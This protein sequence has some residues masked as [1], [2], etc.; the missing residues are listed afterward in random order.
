MRSEHTAT[1]TY[2]HN[3]NIIGKKFASWLGMGATYINTRKVPE[4]FRILCESTPHYAHDHIVYGRRSDGQYIGIG[5][6]YPMGADSLCEINEY[7]HAVGLDMTLTGESTW[8]SPCLRIL[9]QRDDENAERF[10]IAVNCS[11]WHGEWLLCG[12]TEKIIAGV[13]RRLGSHEK[14]HAQNSNMRGW[15]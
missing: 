5:Q 8:G 11:R 3:E 12:E 2:N 14:R 9:F 7:C 1:T 15:L 6:P 10:A 4:G 13:N